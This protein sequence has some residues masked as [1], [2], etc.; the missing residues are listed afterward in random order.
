MPF[1]P[2]DSRINRQ[3]RIPKT[4]RPTNRELKEKELLLLL[5]KFKPH[6]AESIMT[7]AKI[8]KSEKTHEANRLKAAVIILDNYRKLAL[9]LYNEDSTSEDEGTEIQPQDSPI[10]SLKVIENTQDT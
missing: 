2:G 1:A 6:V 10:F 5:R 8:M 3:G 7:A 9:D 4:E